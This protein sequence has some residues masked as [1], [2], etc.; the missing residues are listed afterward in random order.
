[1]PDRATSRLMDFGLVHLATGKPAGVWRVC[2]HCYERRNP[3]PTA[4]DPLQLAETP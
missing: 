1:M 3:L 4:V 2:E